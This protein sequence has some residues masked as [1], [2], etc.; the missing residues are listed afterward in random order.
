MKKVLSITFGLLALITFSA[1]FYI[2]LCQPKDSAV[3]NDTLFFIGLAESFC[4][5]AL[6]L[7]T[8]RLI[9]GTVKAAKKSKSTGKI[10]AI[11]IAALL[12][13]LSDNLLAQ[14]ITRDS[15]G[16]FKAISAPLKDTA[17]KL[18]TYTYTDNKGI[19][20]PVYQSPKG[21][22]FVR[23]ISKSGNPYKMYL[24]D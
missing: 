14:T 22:L 3:D 5:T 15:Q 11:I 2:L 23:K 7:Y 16:N 18:T 13:C 17:A 24:K 12:I 1:S 4:F 19:V 20:L 9:N 8:Q 21:K 10:L 6:F